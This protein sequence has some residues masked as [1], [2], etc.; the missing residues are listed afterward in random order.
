MNE[1][2]EQPTFREVKRTVGR[3]SNKLDLL[4]QLAELNNFQ[5]QLAPPG[6]AV[7]D[8]FIRKTVGRPRP[9]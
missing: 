2:K 6:T 7:D 1:P 4:E 9:G 5:R 8:D 3:G